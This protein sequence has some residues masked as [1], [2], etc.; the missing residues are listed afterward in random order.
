MIR[1]VYLFRIKEGID[2]QTVVDRLLTLKDRVPYIHDIEVAQDFKHT[3][4]SYDIIEQ[5]TFLT[6]EDFISFG[7][8]SYHASI[9]EYMKEVQLDGIKID[10]EINHTLK[11]W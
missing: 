6:K 4:N 2:K 3:D 1:H 10:Y 11:N 5:C 8:D 9:R 7:N